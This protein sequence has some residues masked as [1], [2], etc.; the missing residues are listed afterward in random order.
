MKSFHLTSS[1]M[2]LALLLNSAEAQESTE[3][4]NPERR[5]DRVEQAR[6]E[7][8]GETREVERRDAQERRSQEPEA[9]TRRTNRGADFEP[10][11]DR[12][13]ALLEMIK[14]LRNEVSMLRR[15]LEQ[16][17]M[18]REG[19]RD[20]PREASDARRPAEGTRDQA[21]TRN[22]AMQK[23]QNPAMQ[24]AQRI[25]IA[26][27]KNQDGTVSFEEWLAMREGE[28]TSERRAREQRHFSE[29][30]GDDQKISPEEFFR[31]M[32]RRSRGATREDA[33]RGATR[34]DA[35]RDANRER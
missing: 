29:P 31:W 28:M 22:P 11:N 21:G 12:E 15:Q 10:Q 18:P 3:R 30:A 14:Q 35:A 24:K 17:R 5:Q 2:L 4:N 33:V 34:K 9:E 27:D 32:D 19:Q 26:Y 20:L 7:R 8:G 1:L 16:T 6:G 13:R 23:A 25:F